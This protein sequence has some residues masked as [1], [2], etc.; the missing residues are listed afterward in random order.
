MQGFNYIKLINHGLVRF[1][2]KNQFKIL[3]NV[4]ILGGKCTY[5]GQ[6]DN[7]T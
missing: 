7:Q 3:K 6:V 2:M 5:F 1:K 4:E